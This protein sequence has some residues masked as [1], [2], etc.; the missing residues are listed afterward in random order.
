MATLSRALLGRIR[1]PL[2]LSWQLRLTTSASTGE[3]KQGKRI[4]IISASLN[5][6]GLKYL[7][8]DELRA[9][10]DKYDVN[11][12]GFIDQDEAVK[13]LE[14]AVLTHKDATKRMPHYKVSQFA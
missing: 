12:D 4:A 1:L 13:L 10:F 5:S 6:L 11:K 14:D 3:S 9:Q 8:A 2:Q 7:E